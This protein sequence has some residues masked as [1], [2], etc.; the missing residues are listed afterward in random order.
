ML[1][2]IVDVADVDAP[3]IPITSQVSGVVFG[4]QNQRMAKLGDI[5]IKVAGKDPLPWRVGKLLTD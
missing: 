2:E 5:V 1:G 3:R 4:R